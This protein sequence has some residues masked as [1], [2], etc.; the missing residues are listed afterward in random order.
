[1]DTNDLKILLD[2]YW[3]GESTLDDEAKLHEW[4]KNNSVPDGF[5]AEAQLFG[6][7]AKEK[8]VSI[9]DDFDSKLIKTIQNKDDKTSAKRIEIWPLLTNWKA[10]AV[11]SGIIVASV[12]L[13]NPF[14]TSPTQMTDTYENPQ[15]AY[16]ATKAI[17]LTISSNMNKGKKH[18][19]K[20]SK[21]SEA[22]EIISEVTVEEQ[23]GS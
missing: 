18:A 4:F 19:S 6:Y 20:L 1:M 23:E 13:K 8:S 5:E 15:D 17:L 12:V 21:F 14:G 7:Y 9:S 2:R 22:Q 3:A 10:A 11:I 16:E